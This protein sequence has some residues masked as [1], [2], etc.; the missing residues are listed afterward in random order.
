MARW[1]QQDGSGLI[2]MLGVIATLVI[3]AATL[4]VVTSS[5][6]HNTKRDRDRAKAFNVAEAGLDS[7]L[8]SLAG[9]W[10]DTSTVLPAVDPTAFRGEFDSGEYPNPKTGQ[11][12]AV[13]FYDDLDPVNTSVTWDSNGNGI[14]WI[15]SQAGVG[16]KQARIRTQV[17]RQ[18]I[19]VSTLAPGVAVYSGGDATMSGSSIVSGPLV[20]GQPSAT[21]FVNGNLN[22]GWSCDLT[23]VARQIGG[24]ET[25][26][27]LSPSTQYVGNTIPP[28]SDFMPD[29]VVQS[30]V[31]A[32]LLAQSTGT[33]I[34]Q[35]S[36]GFSWPYGVNYAAPVVVH[37]NLSIGSEG[38]YNFGSL[39]VDGNFSIG[40][41]TVVNCTALHVGGTFTVGG[42]SSTTTHTIGPT[43][44]GGNVVFGG[45][46]CYNMPL[47][48]AEGNIT[49]SG[50]TYVGG[51]GQGA[52]RKPSMFMCV[53]QNKTITYNQGGGQFV[54]VVANMGGGFNMP[55]GR[56]D[57]RDVVG[58]VFAAGAVSL[59]GN[60][61]IVYDA[62]VIN[63]FSGTVTTTAKVVTDTW[64]ELKPQ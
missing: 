25:W 34:S 37:G 6:Q 28:L 29:D 22:R 49:F 26:P 39:W 27:Q 4:I 13:S 53:G 21:F 35:S 51:D 31:Q 50:S 55:G 56:G 43:W 33:V 32:S 60:V 10:P 30:M 18:S 42:G 14:M 54:G 3:L 40:G 9:V 48:V 63:N 20:N 1:R 5:M 38:T 16:A 41:N 59:T 64:Q 44:V 47:L 45:N 61:G 11:F 23:Q 58:A 24:S 19:G 12:I 17:E 15:E 57:R 52:N 36:P 46:N 7:A 62:T 2:M 8:Y